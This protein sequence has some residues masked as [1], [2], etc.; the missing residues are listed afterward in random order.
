MT[1]SC[2]NQEQ[3]GSGSLHQSVAAIGN[4]IARKCPE[5]FP[6][7]VLPKPLP[8]LICAVSTITAK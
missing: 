1:D 2:T 6:Q 7:K 5:L 8:L 3:V 4:L